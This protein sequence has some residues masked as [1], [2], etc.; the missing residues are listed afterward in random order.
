MAITL[1]HTLPALHSG[2]TM[3]PFGDTWLIRTSQGIFSL[4][5][6]A[7]TIRWQE[8]LEEEFFSFK[9]FVVV[10]DTLVY[11]T[12]ARGQGRAD[13]SPWTPTAASGAGA[14]SSIG[15]CSAIWPA[16]PAWTGRYS[17][18]IGCRARKKRSSCNGWRRRP[19]SL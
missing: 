10:G 4:D 17:C 1:R 7:L 3:R 15:R 19:A 5:K 6:Q 11:S 18:S 2:W 14:S 13:R 8:A 9:R 16:S 12:L